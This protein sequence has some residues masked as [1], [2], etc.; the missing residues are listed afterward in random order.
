M[1]TSSFK[2]EHAVFAFETHSQLSV[3]PGPRTERLRTRLPAYEARLSFDQPL[4]EIQLHRFIPFAEHCTGL[5][6]D[7]TDDSPELSVQAPHSTRGF[8]YAQNS[9]HVLR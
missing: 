8:V 6:A 3:T 5:Q 2:S 9:N 1:D 4:L 7:S